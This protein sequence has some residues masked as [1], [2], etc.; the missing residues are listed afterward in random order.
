VAADLVTIRKLCDEVGAKLLY[1]NAHGFGTEVAGRRIP[2][3]I[4]VQIFSFHA[5]KTLRAVEGGLIVWEGFGFPVL[6]AFATGT[7]LI[8]SRT[9]SLP[10]VSGGACL[11][12]DPYSVED[13]GTAMCSLHLDHRL[14]EQL[15]CKGL[16]RAAAFSWDR[17]ARQTLDAYR[18]LAANTKESQRESP[19]Q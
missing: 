4:E 1:D 15:I 8:T 13:I 2:S 16:A 19:I 18:M 17:T 11:L 7:P 10:E 5:T 6:E 12:V 3:E 9:T 14:R